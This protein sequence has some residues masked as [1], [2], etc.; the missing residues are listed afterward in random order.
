LDLFGKHTDSRIWEVLEACGLK[1]LATCLGGL[2]ALIC[3]DEKY[4]G[5]VLRYRVIPEFLTPR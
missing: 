1:E 3:S 2:T 4:G 5:D